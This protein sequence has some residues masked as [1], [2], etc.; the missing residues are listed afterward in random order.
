LR[1]GLFKTLF[2]RYSFSLNS[3]PSDAYYKTY[4]FI[5]LPCHF[6]APIEATPLQFRQAFTFLE[7][8][9]TGGESYS[10]SSN[11]AL[12]AADVAFIEKLET[13]LLEGGIAKPPKEKQ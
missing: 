5:T 10:G 13:K 12:P 1:I 11:L 9:S 2:S 4:E 6:D 7:Q 8:H 3:K